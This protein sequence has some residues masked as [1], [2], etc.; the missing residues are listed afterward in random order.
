MDRAL[1]VCD[2]GVVPLWTEGRRYMKWIGPETRD[3]LSR[4][5]FRGGNFFMRSMLNR[6][7]TE[8]GDGELP[9]EMEV[10]VRKAKTPFQTDAAVVTIQR[11]EVR[12]SMFEAPVS[13]ANRAGRQMPTA[14]RRTLRPTELARLSVSSRTTNRCR[15]LPP[16]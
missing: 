8:Q 4:H 11:A 5:D 15:P 14:G 7:R 12:G 1:R 13:V 10:A 2:F 3:G 16:L 9:Q 6:Y